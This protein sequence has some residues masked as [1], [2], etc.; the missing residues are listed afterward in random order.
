MERTLRLI[1]AST[2]ITGLD[3]T[4]PCDSDGTAR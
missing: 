4:P 1:D 3:L 2:E